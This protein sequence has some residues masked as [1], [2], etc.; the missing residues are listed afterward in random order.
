MDDVEAYQMD[1][2]T[3]QAPLVVGYSVS[4]AGIV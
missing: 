3:S 1:G 4:L 2:R